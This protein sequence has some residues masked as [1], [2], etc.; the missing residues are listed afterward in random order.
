MIRKNQLVEFEIT[1]ITNEGN[2]VGRADGMAVFVPQTAV[3]DIV[4]VQIVKVLKSY[5]YGIVNEIL[6]PSPERIEPDC[7]VFRKCGGCA[8]RHISYEEELRVKGSFVSDS[9]RRL[10][11]FDIECE[12]I[13]GCE[14]RDW[15]RNK[16][17]YPVAMMDGK[18]VCGFYAN[19]SHRVIPFTGCRLQPEVFQQIVDF[20][21]GY[22]N[23]KN[24]PA[25]DEV[26]GKGLIRHIYLRKGY[27]SEEIM[28]C[29]VSKGNR[30]VDIVKQMITETD[31]LKRFSNIKSVV[32]NVN[33]DNTNVILGRKNSTVWG[34]DNITDIM[35]GNKISL[36]PMSFYQV[37]TAQ[38]ERLYALAAEFADLKGS[39]EVFD[40][41]CGAGTIGLSMIDKIDHLTGV[42][43]VKQAVENAKAN[44]EAN[45][46]ENAD[47]ICGDAGE[48]A[49]RLQK[50]GKRPDVVI[51]DPPRKGCDGLTLE[52][53]VKMGPEKIVMISC[54]PATA[55]RDC[56]ILCSEENGYK[57]ERVR[58]VDMFPATV[59]CESVCLLSKVNTRD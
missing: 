5:A 6:T 16:A 1:G 40:L 50:E 21:I 24:I 11:G 53:I 26:S 17:Q 30:A 14:E 44:A 48:I 4:R 8:F 47:F 20:V 33:P 52:S 13:L 3:G 57:L 41:Y 43:V 23:E 38:A 7:P 46:I 15:Y 19:R 18:A 2:G 49:D 35:C 42:E 59:H 36:S 31:I 37:N 56:K 39:E 32:V 45:N 28:L 58:G 25:Y 34:T 10:G 22:L 29:I 12:E 51:V 55:A 54:N 9:F 27:H